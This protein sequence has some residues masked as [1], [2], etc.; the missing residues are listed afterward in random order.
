M[1][2]AQVVAASAPIVGTAT[3]IEAVRRRQIAALSAGGVAVLSG[4]DAY[5]YMDRQ[6]EDLRRE[7][8]GTGVEVLR[9]GDVIV[10]Q[11][12]TDVTFAFDKSD[13]RERFYPV[14]GAVAQTLNRYPATF[15]DVIGHTDAIGSIPY[16]QA[17][18]ERRAA[19]VAGFIDER[20][21]IPARLFVT[22]R[23]KLEPIA[24]NATIEGR[25]ANRRVEILL[26][27]YLGG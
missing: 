17:L 18:S 7:L 1:L 2:P 4:P 25:A 3:D 23:G 27:P 14:L 5:V 8:K 13:I 22:G 24:S 11:L 26:H 21:A 12:P 20:E 9:Q 19:S 16:N 6:A 10:L 15:V